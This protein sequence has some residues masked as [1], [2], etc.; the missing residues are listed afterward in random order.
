MFT[1]E[2]LKRFKNPVNAGEL[3]D[4]NAIGESGDPDCSDVI[5]I[6]IKFENNKVINA[7]FQ[8]YG[9]PGAIS[10]TDVFIDMIKGKDIN[11]ILKI[12]ND[13][14]SDA[15]GGLPLTHMHCSNLP[16]EAFRD[17]VKGYN[18]NEK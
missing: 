1:E 18:K 12:T 8:V 4:C 9:C 16:M 7:K 6:F 2:S 13:Q 3:K 10:T 14:I 15:L 11:K 17:A 5:K